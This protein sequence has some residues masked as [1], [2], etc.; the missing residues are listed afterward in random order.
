MATQP[1]PLERIRTHRFRF[2]RKSPLKQPFRFLTMRTSLRA[3]LLDQK[4]P[5]PRLKIIR[6]IPSLTHE[7][8]AARVKNTARDAP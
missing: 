5:T 6:R 4:K 8:F 7:E 3:P 1:N 2:Y